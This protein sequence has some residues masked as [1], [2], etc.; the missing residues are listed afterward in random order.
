L[1]DLV[2]G[3]DTELVRLPIAQHASPRWEPEPFRYLGVTVGSRLSHLAD[4]RE[5]RTER[6]S[7][8][9]GGLAERLTGL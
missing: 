3:R 6:P 9:L 8:V 7:R 5:S 2:L 4:A 1:A